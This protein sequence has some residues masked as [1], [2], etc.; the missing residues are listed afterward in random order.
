MGFVAPL[1]MAG[2]SI[3]QGQQAKKAANRNAAFADTESN[4]AVNDANAQESMV[5]RQSRESLGRQIAAFGASGV[6]YGG[7]SLRALDSSAINQELDALNTRYKGTVAGYGYGVQSG[8]D[9]EEGNVAQ[10]SGYLS[11]GAA[12]L[13]GYGSSY[14]TSSSLG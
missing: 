6:G 9:R 5:R 8:I 10:T 12:L 1:L 13:K 11:A 7:S 3:Y 14:S 4:M 2:A